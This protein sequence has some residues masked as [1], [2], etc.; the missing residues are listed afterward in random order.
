MDVRC[1]YTSEPSH[2]NVMACGFSE[3]L[4][5]LPEVFFQDV[6]VRTWDLVREKTR[7]GTSDLKR[8]VGKYLTEMDKL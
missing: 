1:S 6:C 8:T 4:D 7:A 2:K 5:S 3:L